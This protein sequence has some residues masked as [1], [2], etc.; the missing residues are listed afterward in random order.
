MPPRRDLCDHRAMRSTR[1]R[2]TIFIARWAILSG[3]AGTVFAVLVLTQGRGSTIDGSQRNLLL[4]AAV[5]LSLAFV[6]APVVRRAFAGSSLT[7]RPAAP[8]RKTLLDEMREGE[9]TA[10]PPIEPPIAPPSRV[11]FRLLV[12]LYLL[13]GIFLVAVLAKL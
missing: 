2:I 1:S 13:F 10:T 7:A 3:L 6:L 8:V 5:L 11:A 9:A 4:V 12:G